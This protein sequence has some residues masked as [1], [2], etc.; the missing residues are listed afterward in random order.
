M[1]GAQQSQQETKDV[2]EAMAE[3]VKQMSLLATVEELLPEPTQF[4]VDHLDV[5]I[6][7]NDQEAKDIMYEVLEVVLP[8]V[9]RMSL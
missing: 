9:L 8:H 6:R 5:L 1:Q 4:T 2:K 3:L 7:I